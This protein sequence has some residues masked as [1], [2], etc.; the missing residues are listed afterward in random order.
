MNAKPSAKNNRE[1]REDILFNVNDCFESNRYSGSYKSRTSSEYHSNSADLNAQMHGRTP[2]PP[3][4]KGRPPRLSI[5]NE[6][7]GTTIPTN[8]DINCNA[9][10]NEFVF[11]PS[12][13]RQNNWGSRPFNGRDWGISDCCDAG[14]IDILSK[15]FEQTQEGSGQTEPMN[16]ESSCI[17]L[18]FESVSHY[19]DEFESP[20]SSSLFGDTEMQEFSSAQRGSFFSEKKDVETVRMDAPFSSR[21]ERRR[22]TTLAKHRRIT[23]VASAVNPT[24]T[25]SKQ[26]KSLF[27]RKPSLFSAR[28]QKIFT[29]SAPE[30]FSQHSTVDIDEYVS[31]RSI[32]YQESPVEDSDI[33]R[34][35]FDFLGENELLSVVGLVSRKWADAATHSHANLMMLSVDACD[36]ERVDE[37]N[38]ATAALRRSWDYMMTTFP[39]ACFLSEGAFKRVYKVFNRTRQEEEA[40]SVM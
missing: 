37:T 2:V 3:K 15:R 29:D 13:G 11:T 10:G 5:E 27:V 16:P 24:E 25:F 32:N 1:I 40:V 7:C 6:P 23:L 34:M 4:L 14:V 18:D 17:G 30:F 28:K 19:C 8:M 20:S 21:A 33:L 9:N 12:I 35:I 36:D 31:P 22:R 39:W 26:R 38:A